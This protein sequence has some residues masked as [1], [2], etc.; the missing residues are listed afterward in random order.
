MQGPRKH[1]FTGGFK[2]R[3]KYAVS[4][5]SLT[6]KSKTAW[7]ENDLHMEPILHQNC[8]TPAR[9]LAQT[10]ASFGLI[11][12]TRILQNHVKM[13]ECRSPLIRLAMSSG[14]LRPPKI[15]TVT[16]WGVA[17][18]VQPIKT[19]KKARGRK[20][21]AARDNHWLDFMVERTADALGDA[22]PSAAAL[23]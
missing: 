23:Q 5:A 1:L 6:F 16:T 14:C 18:T 7:N 13:L 12:G 4:W 9:T 19:L 21:S 11:H 3:A 15:S 8:L 2:H 17:E 10:K 22:F 20:V